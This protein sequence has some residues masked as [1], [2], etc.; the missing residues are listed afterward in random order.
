M[1]VVDFTHE[2]PILNSIYL[3]YFFL[4]FNIGHFAFLL[5]FETAKREP[6]SYY[7]KWEKI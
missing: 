4:T 2:H 6:I 1:T 7:F 5:Y 3:V